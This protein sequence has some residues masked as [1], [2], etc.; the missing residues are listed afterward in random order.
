MHD[1]IVTYPWLRKRGACPKQLRRAWQMFGEAA[2]MTMPILEACADA[3]LDLR[4]LG[5]IVLTDR[6]WADF[7]MTSSSDRPRLLSSRA[8]WRRDM[9]LELDAEVANA[10]G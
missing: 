4:W 2:P 3:G 10:R 5:A 9:L 1:V 6:A 8:N 7:H